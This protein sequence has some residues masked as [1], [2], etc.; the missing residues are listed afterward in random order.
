MQALI[1]EMLKLGFI[2]EES[3]PN[4]LEWQGK[5]QPAQSRV[6]IATYQDH[7]MAMSFAPVALRI[8]DQNEIKHF[9]IED[10]A[11]VAKSYPGFWEDLKSCG[12]TI[13]YK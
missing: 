6:S 4:T 1:R 11:V 5:K 2:L 8:K 10:P 9:E 13:E 12:F 7:R 3:S